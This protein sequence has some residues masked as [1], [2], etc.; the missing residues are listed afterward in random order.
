[1]LSFTVL[2]SSVLIHNVKNNQEHKKTLNEKVWRSAAANVLFTDHIIHNTTP[3]VKLKYPHQSVERIWP[4]V[5]S[6]SPSSVHLVAYYIPT[7][8]TVTTQRWASFQQALRARR[9]RTFELLSGLHTRHQ[10]GSAQP[11]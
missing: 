3:P 4:S 7:L 2:M 6:T 11:Q 1:M 5:A 9:A 8:P 10:Y